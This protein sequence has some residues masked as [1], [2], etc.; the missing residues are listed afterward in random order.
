MDGANTREIVQS[1]TEANVPTVMGNP[2]WKSSSIVRIL[3][4]EKYCG[5][6]LMQKTFT[7]DYLLIKR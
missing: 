1:L 6:V 5:D 7:V 2:V 4:N 3:R